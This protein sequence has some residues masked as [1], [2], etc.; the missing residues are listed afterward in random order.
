MKNRNSTASSF[1]WSF[2]VNA[3]LFL[4]LE[5][6]K[7]AKSLRVEGK[8]EDIVIVLSDNTKIYAQAKS[9][10]KPDDIASKQKI[11]KL[12]EAL[13]T[14]N[15]DFEKK[16]SKIFIYIT[17]FS[18]P[19]TAEKSGQLDG[20]SHLEFDELTKNSQR[21]IIKIIQDK[22]FDNIIPEFLHFRVLPFYGRDE[23]K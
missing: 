18:N 2:Q 20:L 7:T 8:D 23:K 16:D 11:D 3:A 4:F 12:S 17:N 19:T 5:Y 1:G 6:L 13:E 15:D 9:T 14:L 10:I 21:I 22:N